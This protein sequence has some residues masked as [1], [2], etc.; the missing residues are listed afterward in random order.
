MPVINKLLLFEKKILIMLLRSKLYRNRIKTI[1]VLQFFQE[2]ET[3]GNST[4]W[5]KDLKL[6]DK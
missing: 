1:W 4:F 6:F 5:L 2:C 3:K